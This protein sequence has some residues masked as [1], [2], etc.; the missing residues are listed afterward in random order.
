MTFGRPTGA[1][2]EVPGAYTHILPY[3]KWI[4]DNLVIEEDYLGRPTFSAKSTWSKSEFLNEH[5]VREI[6][7]TALRSGSG[8]RP[9]SGSTTKMGLFVF[10]VYIFCLDNPRDMI[11]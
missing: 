6:K 9:E 1:L 3:Q 4:Q 10:Q 2:E 7:E 8:I 5:L 11:Y